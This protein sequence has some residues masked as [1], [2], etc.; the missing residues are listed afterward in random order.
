MA[1]ALHLLASGDPAIALAAI[2][3]QLEAGDHVRVVLL[4]GAA[5]PTLPAGVIVHRVPGDLSYDAL[6]D[7]IYA[8][9]SVVAW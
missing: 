1:A 9:D 4:A 8:A 2:A 6:L 5:S 3:R 7:A